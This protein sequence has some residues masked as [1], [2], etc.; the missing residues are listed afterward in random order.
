MALTVTNLR[1]Q[2]CRNSLRRERKKMRS[3]DDRVRTLLLTCS[4]TLG[5]MG[6]HYEINADSLYLTWNDSSLDSDSF[7]IERRSADSGEFLF[8]AIVPGHQTWYSD[9][10]L[11]YNTT[12]CYRV[13]AYNRAGDSPYSHELCAT[14]LA[15]GPTIKTIST[16]I[17]SGS[18]LSGSSVIWTAVPSGVPLRVEFL[19][20]DT[21]SGTELIA[22]YQFNGDPSGVLNT[23]M[24]ANGSHQ[25][26]VRAVYPDSSTAE[27]TVV[28]TV[29]NTSTTAT[30]SRRERRF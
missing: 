12:Y 24:L 16:N 9:H 7:E 2:K 6:W 22:P 11:A 18:V 21:L 1:A 13:R 19:I 25:L 15:S 30:T 29:S 3:T 26:K 14:T 23:N 10:N 17:S 27:R 8:I 5:V 28:V 4:L 20:N